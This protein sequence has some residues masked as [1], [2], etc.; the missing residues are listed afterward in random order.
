MFCCSVLEPL[1]SDDN[2]IEYF[3]KHSNVGMCICHFGRTVTSTSL[4]HTHT[5]SSRRWKFLFFNGVRLVQLPYT[6]ELGRKLV[7]GSSFT[8]WLSRQ[9][10]A[11][12]VMS[13]AKSINIRF[14]I[15]KLLK[16]LQNS[17]SS[18]DA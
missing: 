9:K 6:I 13:S 1:Y 12:M 11:K 4:I 3:W 2:F 15:G 10:Q 8:F 16:K 5:Q 17:Q 18:Y 7:S 14:I